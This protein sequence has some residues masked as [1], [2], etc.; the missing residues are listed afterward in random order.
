MSLKKPIKCFDDLVYSLREVF[1]DDKVEVEEVKNIMSSYQS[2]PSEWLEYVY[3][4]RHRYKYLV[5]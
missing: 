3:F 2:K 5:V 4:D 1:V